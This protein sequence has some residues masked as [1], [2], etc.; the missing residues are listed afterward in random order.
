MTTTRLL[1]FAAS[2]LLLSPHAVKAQAIRYDGLAS[3]TSSSCVSGKQC[4]LLVLPGTQVNVC[5][6]SPATLSGCLASP[7]QTYRDSGAGTPCATTSQL[8]PATGGACLATADNQGNYGFWALPG[9]YS[10]FMR[11]PA[12]AGGGTYGPYPVSIHGDSGGYTFDALYATLPLACAAAGSGTLAITKAWNGLTTQTFNCNITWTATGSFRPASGQTVT[13]AGS[14]DGTLNKHIDLSSGGHVAILQH[15]VSLHPEWTG[16]VGNGSTDDSTAWTWLIDV[17]STSGGG[18]V[19]LSQNFNSYVSSTINLPNTHVRITGSGGSSVISG[20]AT[21]V[22]QVNSNG[23]NITT[24]ENFTITDSNTSGNSA[25]VG[26]LVNLGNTVSIKRMQITGWTAHR[27]G[28]G[29]KI[30]DS[31]NTHIEDSKVSYWGTGVL[32]ATGTSANATRLINTTVF[33]NAS[34][35]W[36]NEA[37]GDMSAW[38]CDFEGNGTQGIYLSSASNGL[39]VSGSHFEANT[40]NHIEVSGGFYNSSGNTYSGGSLLMDS[41]TSTV[42]I[43]D[44]LGSVSITNNSSIGSFV[45]GLVLFYPILYASTPSGSG[46]TQLFSRLGVQQTNGPSTYSFS[47]ATQYNFDATW[48]NSAY[49]GSGQSYA[50]FDSLGIVVRSN[51]PCR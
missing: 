35:G 50:C 5:Q 47:G 18:E 11:V 13:L 12:T 37:A 24:L 2:C 14:V 34:R 39:V 20:T 45:P 6:G 7:A 38:G 3:T 49:S 40:S 32:T 29:I 17:V 8:T 25:T 41:G 51:S 21:T 26:V 4:P 19:E 9:S 42:S 15:S 22:L 33:G 30:S 31:I 44:Y 43:N 16:A 46:W 23:Q 27:L 48:F 28:I 36:D 1:F 10:Y